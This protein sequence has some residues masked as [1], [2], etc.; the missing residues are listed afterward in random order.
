MPDYPQCYTYSYSL[1]KQFGCSGPR[2][3]VG[4]G[5]RRVETLCA[6]VSVLGALG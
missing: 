6:Y 2:E 3:A 1:T 5:D 4:G